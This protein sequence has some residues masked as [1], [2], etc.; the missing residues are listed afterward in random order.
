MMKRM[1]SSSPVG[2]QWHTGA[3]GVRWGRGVLGG[4][5]SGGEGGSPWTAFPGEELHSGLQACSG[6]LRGV[7][8]KARCH[9]A[10]GREKEA[11]Q[12]K[13]NGT[14]YTLNTKFKLSLKML[15]VLNIEFI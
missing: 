7:Y 13:L 2:G 3:P 1:R 15:N 6:P 11:I 9:T 4:T 5:G 12:L 8:C 10:R 14:I